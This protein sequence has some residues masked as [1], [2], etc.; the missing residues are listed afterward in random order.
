MPRPTEDEVQRAAD[1]LQAH[2]DRQGVRSRAAMM[3]AIGVLVA[4][5]RLPRLMGATE[6]A[7][8]LGTTTSSLPKW[9]G[10]PEPLYSRNH[11]DPRC[12]LKAGSFRDADEVE[13]FKDRREQQ[14]RETAA[15][16]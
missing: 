12:R 6:V 10:L 15:A 1:V 2:A 7:A 16:S 4:A 3:E 13:E 5:S 11:P 9:T 14:A 8:A